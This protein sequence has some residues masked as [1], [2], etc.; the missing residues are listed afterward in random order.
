MWKDLPTR[1]RQ[2]VVAAAGGALFLRSR[3]R[4][5]RIDG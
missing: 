4:L 1:K 3:T 5:Y 2:T